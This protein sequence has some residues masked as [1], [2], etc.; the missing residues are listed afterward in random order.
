[1]NIPVVSM[2]WKNLS[3]TNHILTGMESIL[4]EEGGFC[5][6]KVISCFLPLSASSYDFNQPSPP[7]GWRLPRAL[8]TCLNINPGEQFDW[9]LI[10]ICRLRS[11]QNGDRGNPHWAVVSLRPVHWALTGGKAIAGKVTPGLP[12]T[13]VCNWL[14]TCHEGGVSPLCLPCVG[15]TMRNGTTV[16][17]HNDTNHQ[18][19]MT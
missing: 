13:S 12:V 7:S 5:R 3:L 9:K 11:R 1:M 18:W 19:S 4:A 10:S 6:Q 17:T 16:N 15:T 14:A 2:S 8:M